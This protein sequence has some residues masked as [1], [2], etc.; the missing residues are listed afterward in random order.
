[1]KFLRVAALAVLLALVLADPARAAIDDAGCVDS[2]NYAFG[3]YNCGSGY[4]RG[5]KYACP[6]EECKKAFM[7]VAQPCLAEGYR[8][9]DQVASKD[10]GSADRL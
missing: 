2:L 9:A 10:G 1:M 5:F 4:D 7:L 8:L 3:N 6:N